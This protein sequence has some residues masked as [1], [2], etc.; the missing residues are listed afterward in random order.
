MGIKW[1]TMGGGTMDMYSKRWTKHLFV[2]G[3]CCHMN[4]PS[5]SV[6]HSLYEFI[7]L[8]LLQQ[9]EGTFQSLYA[10]FPICFSGDL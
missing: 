5:S 9:R 10:P 1:I 2:C 6:L 3:S 8:E 7:F 4:V